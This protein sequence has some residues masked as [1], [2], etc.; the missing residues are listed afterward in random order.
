MSNFRKWT[1]E[2]IKRFLEQGSTV[3]IS[4]YFDCKYIESDYSLSFWRRLWWGF[5]D[6]FWAD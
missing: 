5:L 3:G 2:D 4:Q 1:E 6:W